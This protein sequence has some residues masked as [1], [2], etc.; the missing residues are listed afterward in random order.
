MK[1]EHGGFVPITEVPPTDQFVCTYGGNFAQTLALN[2][3]Q[4]ERFLS[5]ASLDGRVLLQES[6]IRKPQ[7]I[8]DGVNPD[9][10]VAG[11]GS[12]RWG[13]KLEM[14]DKKQ[15]PY[16]QVDPDSAGWAISIN[17]D[18]IADDLMKRSSGNAREVEKKFA[19]K[20]N[21]YLSVGLREALLKDKFT[22]VKDPFVTGRLFASGASLGGW[23]YFLSIPTADG[24]EKLPYL[25]GCLFPHILFG[26]MN[27]GPFH[28]LDEEFRKDAK[29]GIIYYNRFALSRILNFN[30][31]T[32]LSRIEAFDF[33]FE[34]D[35]L[36][37]AYGYLDFNKYIGR[38][39]LVKA[40]D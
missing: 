10:S 40:A 4:I 32:V 18:L 3:A 33:P 39:P 26:S 16:F 36:T 1:V 5:I 20:F 28:E 37:L 13:Q 2:R 12:L 27:S 35:R 14:E 25:V 29:L 17:G 31:R 21:Y 19:R 23:M 15:N 30:R 11:R 24:L 8:P 7:A 22:R 6:R 9:G 38:N 34:I